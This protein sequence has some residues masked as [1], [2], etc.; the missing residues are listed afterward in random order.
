MRAVPRWRIWVYSS[1]SGVDSDSIAAAWYQVRYIHQKLSEANAFHSYRLRWKVFI[2]RILA[3]LKRSDGGCLMV[4]LLRNNF[5]LSNL[6]S[7]FLS[8]SSS[9]YCV[10]ARAVLFSFDDHWNDSVAWLVVT[11]V[12]PNWITVL[13]AFLIY[14]AKKQLFSFTISDP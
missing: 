5:V 2:G 13:S 7:L 9:G 11:V 8:R 14:Q 12:M 4:C 10:R 6:K 3:I 1:K